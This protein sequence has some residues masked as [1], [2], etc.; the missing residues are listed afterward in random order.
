M[1]RREPGIVLEVEHQHGIHRGENYHIPEG[2]GVLADLL[3]EELKVIRCH[4]RTA[5][6]S[7]PLI[8]VAHSRI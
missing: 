6:R 7:A 2:P 8:S 5:A 1:L 4:V 3:F